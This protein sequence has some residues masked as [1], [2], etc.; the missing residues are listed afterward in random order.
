[1][2][3]KLKR[4]TDKF[5]S[6]ITKSTL[7]MIIVFLGGIVG[8]FIRG[9]YADVNLDRSVFATDI[10]VLKQKTCILED[11]MP[12]IEKK[13]DKLINMHLGR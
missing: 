8:W 4:T 11:T 2:I 9:W 7:F 12:K 5:S 3:Q 6:K 10:Q 1:M 13:L